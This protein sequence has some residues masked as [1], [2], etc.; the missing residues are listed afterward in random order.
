MG[1]ARSWQG[2]DEKLIQNF[3]QETSWKRSTFMTEEGTGE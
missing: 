2:Y 3:G 1:W